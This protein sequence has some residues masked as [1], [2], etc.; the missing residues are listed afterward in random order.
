[1]EEGIAGLAEGIGVFLEMDVAENVV[2]A[3][4]IVHM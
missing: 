3:E 2:L 4:N 1:M